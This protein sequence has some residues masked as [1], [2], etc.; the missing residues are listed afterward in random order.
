VGLSAAYRDRRYEAIPLAILLFVFPVIYYITHTDIHY[1]HPIDPV[2]VIFTVYGVN[3]SKKQEARSQVD[4]LSERSF[5]QLRE[6]I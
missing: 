6:L 2:L 1:R 4:A 3:S 5:V